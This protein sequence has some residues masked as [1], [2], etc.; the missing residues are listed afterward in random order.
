MAQTKTTIEPPRIE[1]DQPVDEDRELL[2]QWGFLDDTEDVT[3]EPEAASPPAGITPFSAFDQ[4]D[5]NSDTNRRLKESLSG[6]SGVLSEFMDRPDV[7][8]AAGAVPGLGS[9]RAPGN[10]PTVLNKRWDDVLSR[11]VRAE[12]MEALQPALQRAIEILKAQG[13]E[14]G[15]AAV[16]YITSGAPPNTLAAFFLP[17]NY[18]T[19]W[20]ETPIKVNPDRVLKSVIPPVDTFAHEFAHGADYAAAYRLADRYGVNA[21]EEGFAPLLTEFLGRNISN[22]GLYRE[23]QDELLRLPNWVT[24]GDRPLNTL[25]VPIAEAFARLSE[26]LIFA[27]DMTPTWRALI[28]AINR[29]ASGETFLP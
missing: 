24:Y 6:L 19:R 8:S 1:P 27:D 17:K 9:V 18:Q 25:R 23:L 12:D 29:L 14:G 5:P 4:F 10:L 3:E 15:L 20:M 26:P 2:R 22:T 28:Q 7:Q 11:Y 21:P 13:R 16:D